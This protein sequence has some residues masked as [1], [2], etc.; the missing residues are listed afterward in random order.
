[1]MKKILLSVLV[2][3]VVWGFGVGVCV[4]EK[5]ELKLTFSNWTAPPSPPGRA[6]AKWIEMVQERTKGKVKVNAMYSSTLLSGKNTI[7]GVIRGAADIGMNVSAFRPERFPMLALLNYPHPYKHTMVPIRIAWDMYNKFDPPEF[8]GVKVVSFSCNGLGANGCGFYGRFPVTGLSDL[9]GK[10]IRATGTGV[11]ALEKL[12]ASPVFLPVGETYEALQKNIVKG[13]YTTFEIIRPFKFSEVIDYIT[14][15]P[16][17]GAV[18]FTIVKKKTFNSWP[19][20]VKKVIED[21]KMEHSE[22]AGNYAHKE[23]QGGLTFAMSKG[24]K[25]TTV[26]PEETKKMLQLLKPLTNDWL[27]Q[28]SA[29]GLPAK[30]WLD[31][32]HRLLAKY[33]AQY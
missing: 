2:V 1:M 25:K 24:I 30:D 15:F 8:K 10:E 18:M 3:S 5:P 23:G 9:K 21:M 4:A 16:A 11:Q 26:S 28:N 22:W 7:E 13:L 6:T 20:D 27:K 19:A 31:E 33:N 29:K 14:P 17:P 12:G 32:F